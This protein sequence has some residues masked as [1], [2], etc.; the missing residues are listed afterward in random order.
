[1]L[2]ATMLLIAKIHKFK[3]EAVLY[4][5]YSTIARFLFPKHKNHPHRE[6]IWIKFPE[7]IS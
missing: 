4:V 2:L 1:M 5:P 6:E 3:F 7:I